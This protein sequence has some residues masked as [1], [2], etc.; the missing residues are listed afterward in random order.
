MHTL[1][2]GSTTID[3]GPLALNL[4]MVPAS[5]GGEWVVFDFRTTPG[6]IRN[7]VQLFGALAKKLS[8][9]KR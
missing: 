5:G 4:S 7:V 1:I 8:Y 6:K 2:L 9:F 3:G